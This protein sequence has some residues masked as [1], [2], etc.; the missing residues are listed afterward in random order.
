M[1]GTLL[2]IETY[3]QYLVRKELLFK[4]HNNKIQLKCETEKIK[5]TSFIPQNWTYTIVNVKIS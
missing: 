3:T 4:E 5:T 1:F 2:L